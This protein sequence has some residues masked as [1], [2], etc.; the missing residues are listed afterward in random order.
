MRADNSSE[1]V[2]LDIDAK[3][4]KVEPRVQSET[5]SNR[6]NREHGSSNV[7]SRG[8]QGQI[9]EAAR[10]QTSRT[11]KRFITFELHV[12]DVLYNTVRKIKGHRA[13]LRDIHEMEMSKRSKR[14]R[15]WI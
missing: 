10:V 5:Q 9:S 7:Q 11:A 12:T 1:L 4:S 13:C 2:N 3:G 6:A 8:P 15:N 14:K